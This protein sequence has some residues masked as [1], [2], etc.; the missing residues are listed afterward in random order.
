ME[1][2][3]VPPV[4]ERSKEPPHVTWSGVEGKTKG[5]VATRKGSVRVEPIIRRRSPPGSIRARTGIVGHK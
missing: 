1:D 5:K 4:E 2:D 3:G